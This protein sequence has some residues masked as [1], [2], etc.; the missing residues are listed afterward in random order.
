MKILL[1]NASLLDATF[2]YE[3]Q[4]ILVENG[5]I[6][7]LG[8]LEHSQAD[9]VIDLSGHTV[10]P[11]FI[12]AHVHVTMG[13][14]A[15][16][17]DVLRGFAENGVTMI[18]DMGY[19]C[20]ADVENYFAWLRAHSSPEYTQ[21]VSVGRFVAYPGGYG[22]GHGDDITGVLITTPEEARQAVRQQ[23]RTGS[24]AIKIGL[25]SMSI[26]GLAGPGRP[27]GGPGGGPPASVE[28][29]MPTEL[30]SAV[31]AEAKNL[32]VRSICHLM[33]RE[34]MQEAVRSGIGE[35][36]HCA[37]EPISDE[38]L[39]E[40]VQ[41]NVILTPTLEMFEQIAPQKFPVAAENVKRYFDKGGRITV[42]NDYM[43]G[44]PSLG[45][46]MAELR[47]LRKAGLSLRD[48]VI[49]ATQNGAVAAGTEN[50]MGTISINK[51]A[52]LIAIRGV[53]DDSMEALEHLCMVMNRGELLHLT[54]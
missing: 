8:A 11:G 22:A 23:I 50:V 25:G 42:G 43:P 39:E 24:K 33:T 9:Q 32:G 29:D 2:D 47:A 13:D 27:G 18:R 6:T 48:I 26:P 15:F 41:K 5:I 36:A 40:M 30:I 46:A 45:M 31:C 54:I 17:E 14:G 20:T 53:L 1:K 34:Y 28:M 44:K 4:D 12:N 3:T 37:I 16:R 21:V 35:V 10:M 49:A 51:Q 38:L 52:N 7:G 19:S